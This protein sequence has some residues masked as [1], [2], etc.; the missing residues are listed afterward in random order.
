MKIVTL[1]KHMQ[2]KFRMHFVHKSEGL[3]DRVY[4]LQHKFINNEYDQE[5]PQ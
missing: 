1:H 3:E 5:V 2:N 4:A